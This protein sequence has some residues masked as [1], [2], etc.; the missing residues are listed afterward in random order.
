VTVSDVTNAH[1]FDPAQ[2]A[3]FLTA[4][5]KDPNA[6]WFRSI[7]KDRR[8]N[9]RRYGKDLPGFNPTELTADCKAGNAVYAVIGNATTATGENEKGPTGCVCDKDITSCPALFVEWDDQSIE[10]QLTAW[11]EHFHLPEPSV[12]VLTG[13]KSVHAYW[14]LDQPLPPEQWKPIQS[15]LVDHCKGDTQCKNPSRLMRLPGSVY[16]DKKTGQPTGQARIHTNPGHRYSL[17]TITA[18]LPAPPPEPTPQAPAIASKPPGL[19]SGTWCGDLPPRPP[20]ALLDALRLVPAFAHNANQREQLLGLAMRLHVEVGAKEAQQLL[21]QTCCQQI[22]DLPA[23]FNGQPNGIRA[24]SVWPY[25]RD[26]WG[27]DISRPDLKGHKP[28][29]QGKLQ[30]PKAEVNQKDLRT[31]LREEMASAG[32][33][34][35]LREGLD[36]LDEIRSPTERFIALQRLKDLAGLTSP[37]AFDQAIATLIDERR[38]DDDCTLADLMARQHDA[39][40]IIDQF[41]A[42]GALVGLGGDRGDGKTILMYAAAVAVASG[43]PLFGELSVQQGPAVIVQCDESSNNAKKKFLTLGADPSLPI[44]WM[45]G[46]NPS[47]LP[48]LKRKITHTKAKFVGIDSVTT[49]AGGRGIKSSDPE[50]SLFLYQ[51]NSLAAEMGVLI[52]VLIHLRKSDIKKPRTEVTL[53]DFL[54]TGMLTAACSDVFGYWPNKASDAFPHQFVLRCLGKRNCEAG[55]TWDLQ[56]NRDD[57]SLTFAGV[58]GGGATPSQQKNALGKALAY[59]RQRPGT[60]CSNRD[61]AAAIGV[62]EETIRKGLKDYFTNGNAM[63]IQRVGG[64]PGPEGGRPKIQWIF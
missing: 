30:A 59:L 7:G 43:Q 42:T 41:G 60:P 11:R 20:E 5:G 56:G 28:K 8:V 55:V 34:Q 4:L 25:L 1:T 12:M 48:E 17:E 46:F 23:Y 2:A 22:N 13:G 50:F 33:T 52:I 51:L 47:M 31:R 35:V 54:G 61:I 62:E 24:G 58:Q 6:T 21:R 57:F 14:V 26:H 27:I 19:V 15:R 53:D 9:R 32:A 44:H 10:W 45:W 36:L 63:K 38:N 49:V 40:F 18:C 16:F 37:K 3:A 29:G 39:S 64:D